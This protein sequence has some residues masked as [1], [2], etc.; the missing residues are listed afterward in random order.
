ME[1]FL[2]KNPGLRSRI[3]FHIP[4][5]DYSSRELC[6]IAT[7]IASEK[8]L[9]LT[10]EA[11]GKLER[12]FEEACK[13]SDFGNGRYVRNMIE[14]AKM[15]QANRLMAMNMDDI[16]D[17]DIRTLCADDIEIPAKKQQEKVIKIGFCA[18]FHIKK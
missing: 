8:G 5:E 18:K 16:R 4:F 1:K 10:E 6:E 7:L 2:E 14:K 11:L 15:A 17:E 3:A 13:S 12:N 9:I